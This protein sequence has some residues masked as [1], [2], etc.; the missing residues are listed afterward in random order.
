MTRSST[1]KFAAGA[2]L[3]LVFLFSFGLRLW[4][5][6]SAPSMPELLLGLGDSQAQGAQEAF[7]AR[8]RERFP[9]GSPETAMVRALQ[10][11]GFRIDLRRKE[12][13]FDRAADLED[14]CRRGGAARWSADA[15]GRIAEISGGYYI[16]CP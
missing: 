7:Q 16:H 11:Q 6:R 15:E 1:L 10:E 8:L 3:L 4:W 13:G 2:L 5:M 12:A 14:H 9:P